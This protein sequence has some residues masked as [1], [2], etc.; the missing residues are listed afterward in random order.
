MKTFLLPWLFR[1]FGPF[2]GRS[3]RRS[4]RIGT[5]SRNAYPTEVPAAEQGRSQPVDSPASQEI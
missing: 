1:P 3:F 4:Q 5:N 2:P